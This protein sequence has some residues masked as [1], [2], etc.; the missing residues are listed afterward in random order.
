MTE[1]TWLP[2]LLR[3]LHVVCVYT[4]RWDAQIQAHLPSGALAAYE[5]LKAACDA[6]ETIL[7]PIVKSAEGN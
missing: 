2:T 4:A 1:R 6:F 3:I 5:A 7:Y